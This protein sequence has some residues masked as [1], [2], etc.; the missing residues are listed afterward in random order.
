VLYYWA[1]K[2]L[3]QK[4]DGVLW[5]Y[6]RT[7]PP[8]VPELLKA[9]GLS[10]RKNIDTDEATYLKAILENGLNPDDYSDMLQLVRNTKKSSFF[11][12]VYL[13]NPSVGMVKEVVADFFDTAEEIQNAKKFPR[14]MTK[15]CRSCSYY[16][17]C[18]LEIR[19]LDSDLV[20]KQ[21]FNVKEAK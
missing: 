21:M 16:Q 3:G 4:C 15:D 7:K 19:G 8:A 1:L 17:I 10:K 18:S 9:G 20:R 14:N 11:K 5:D 13:P 2:E 12:R 6:I